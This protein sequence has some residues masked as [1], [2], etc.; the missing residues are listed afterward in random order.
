MH[1][2]ARDRRSGTIVALKLYRMHKL[3]DISRHQVAREVRLHMGLQ[4]ENIIQLYA[5]WQEAGNVV[6]LQVS[7]GKACARRFSWRTLCQPLQTL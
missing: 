6:L 2:Q 7:R 5:S 3:N 4:H 1:V